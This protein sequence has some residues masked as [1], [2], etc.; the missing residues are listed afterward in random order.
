MNATPPSTRASPTLRITAAAVCARR[1]A[2]AS[3]PDSASAASPAS[4][5]VVSARVS[6]VFARAS[7][8]SRF[9]SAR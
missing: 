5:S 7:S 9:S 2:S 3:S 1:S 8:G 4:T 6:P